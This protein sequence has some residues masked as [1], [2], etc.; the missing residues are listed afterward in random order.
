MHLRGDLLLGFDHKRRH[1]T[2][3][4]VA[5]DGLPAARAVVQ[6]RVAARGRINV[7]QFA[8]GQSQ[9]LRVAHQQRADAFRLLPV[10]RFQ[11]CRNVEHFVAFISLR[12]DGALIRR[13][14]GFEH[15]DRTKA[16]LRQTFG[17]QPYCHARRAGRRFDLHVGG[18]MN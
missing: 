1:I 16:E 17:P 4:G 12:N 2:S 15:F 13:L 5:R 14:N 3:A 7:R 10:R 18:A 11:N 9:A 8:Q 6:N